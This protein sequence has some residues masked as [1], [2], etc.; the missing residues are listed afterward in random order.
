MTHVSFA[1]FRMANLLC[2]ELAFVE[3]VLL[4]ED[5]GKTLLLLLLRF[6]GLRIFISEDTRSVGVVGG[7]GGAQQRRKTKWA[8]E[9]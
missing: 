1:T 7:M 5:S 4:P 2:K 9:G 3:F 8:E 6:L